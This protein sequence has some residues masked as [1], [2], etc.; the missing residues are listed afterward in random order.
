MRWKKQKN[1][2]K[3]F[4]LFFPFFIFVTRMVVVYVPG[5]LLD[6][7]I[8]IFILFLYIYFCI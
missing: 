8:T 6:Q 2:V 4:S 3:I 1:D 7:C 5:I